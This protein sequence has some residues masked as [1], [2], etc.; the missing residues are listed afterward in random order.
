MTLERTIASAF[1]MKDETWQRHASPWS[2]WTR[3]SVLPLLILAFWSRIW[4]GWGSLIPIAMAVGWMWYNPRI[5]NKPTSTNNWASKAVLGERVWLNRDQI[6]VPPHHRYLPNILS[7]VAASG[8]IFVILG[9]I[10]LK[11]WPTFLG[12]ILLNLSKLWFIDRMV[13]LYE[14]MKDQVPEYKQWLY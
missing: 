4:L 1:D 13:W 10:T 6:P 7:G 11:I 2:V 8:I 3:F 9:V 14:D 5:F 12:I